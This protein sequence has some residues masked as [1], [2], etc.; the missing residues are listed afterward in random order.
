MLSV[1]SQVH[2]VRVQCL[3]LG[4]WSV[5][6]KLPLVVDFGLCYPMPLFTVELCFVYIK[7]L[8]CHVFSFTIFIRSCYLLFLMVLSI[9]SKTK[10]SIGIQTNS[11]RLPYTVYEWHYS[12][13]FKLF[14]F[15]LSGSSL[16]SFRYSSQK[17][18][19][20]LISK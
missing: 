20:K 9:K 14:R 16:Y 10:Q 6:Y 4:I 13:H 3:V 11:G 15:P 17:M 7:L 8:F 12:R 1:I 19:Q 18:K 2:W 5:W